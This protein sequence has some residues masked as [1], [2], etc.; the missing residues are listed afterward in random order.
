M[1]AQIFSLSLWI[2]LVGELHELLILQYC[3]FR[4]SCQSRRV[5]A[6]G[7]TRLLILSRIATLGLQAL[8]TLKAL[9]VD[10][11]DEIGEVGA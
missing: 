4:V 2:G 8:A 3:D 7:V 10:L 5:L 11:V 6:L 1:L 9:L